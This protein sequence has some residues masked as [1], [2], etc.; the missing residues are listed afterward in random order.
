MID[1]YDMINYLNQLPPPN[2]IYRPA[3]I[4]IGKLKQAVDTLNNKMNESIFGSII[5]KQI[6]QDIINSPISDAL[7][8]QAAKFDFINKFNYFINKYNVSPDIVNLEI[9]RPLTED[10]LLDQFY[11]K[12]GVFLPKRFEKSYYN[13]YNGHQFFNQVVNVNNTPIEYIIPKELPVENKENKNDNPKEE[14]SKKQEQLQE[15]KELLFNSNCNGFEEQKKQY[16]EEVANKIEAD[17]IK[18]M[19]E[20]KN[21]EETFSKDDI[22]KIRDLYAAF[23]NGDEISEKDLA[24]LDKSYR[25]AQAIALVS[26]LIQNAHKHRYFIPDAGEI[27]PYV[28]MESNMIMAKSINIMMD[29]IG[30]KQSKAEIM[31]LINDFTAQPRKLIDAF[32][33]I[34]LIDRDGFVPTIMDIMQATKDGKQ[35]TD[36]APYKNRHYRLKN[37]KSE[38]DFV[39]QCRINDLFNYIS[40]VVSNFPNHYKRVLGEKI[41]NHLLEMSEGCI[42]FTEAKDLITKVE[43]ANKL[44][45]LLKKMVNTLNIAYNKKLF[46][47]QRLIFITYKTEEIGRILGGVKRS[48]N[49]QMNKPPRAQTNYIQ[50]DSNNMVNNPFNRLPR[51]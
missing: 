6:I 4:A 33:Q 43:V 26:A 9:N 3:N 40:S 13:F 30:D 27:S 23:S 12:Y 14:P 10:V 46:A 50:R 2:F 44:D 8:L 11:N 32:G 39:L 47:N 5:G 17:F 35:V 31:E 25:N 1:F 29:K 28:L 15:M 34:S 16:S 24:F 49:N 19:G 48:L 20:A 41:E 18:S 37:V 21:I 42:E 51:R 7:A 22:D 36:S 45:T 38:T